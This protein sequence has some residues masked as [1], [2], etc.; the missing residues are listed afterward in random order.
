MQHFDL[1]RGSLRFPVRPPPPRSPRIPQRLVAGGHRLGFPVSITYEVR[2]NGNL[3]AVSATNAVSLSLLSTETASPARRG[4]ECVLGVRKRNRDHARGASATPD[5]R[6]Y[7]QPFRTGVF[8][9]WGETTGT[10][11]PVSYRLW[12]SINGGTF[13]AIATL[14]GEASRSYADNVRTTWKPIR[15]VVFGRRHARQRAERAT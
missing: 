2:A 15:Y 5:G 11:P 6:I 9:N 7:P 1:M 3:V 4:G 12:R 8:V 14:T 13:S 10:V